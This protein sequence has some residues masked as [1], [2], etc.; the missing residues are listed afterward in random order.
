MT[1]QLADELTTTKPGEKSRLK[2]LSI[3][4]IDILKMAEQLVD[5]FTM[6]KPGEKSRWFTLV[7]KLD[8]HCSAISS[9]WKM[10][11]HM[12]GVWKA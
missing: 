1:E 6:T 12:K 8:I 7:D 10:E 3:L 4:L 5:E 11:L 9:P 2:L